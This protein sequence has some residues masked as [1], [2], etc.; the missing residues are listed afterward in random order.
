[1]LEK[2]DVVVY[3][4]LPC[5]VRLCKKEEKV[6]NRIVAAETL[7]YLIQVSYTVLHLQLM[8]YRSVMV[9]NRWTGYSFCYPSNILSYK[10]KKMNK[11]TCLIKVGNN[12]FLPFRQLSTEQL[13]FYLIIPRDRSIMCV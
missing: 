4:V 7:A 10:F 9:V 1:M 6:E 2:E 11:V 8:N 13:L 3:R 5:L 12:K